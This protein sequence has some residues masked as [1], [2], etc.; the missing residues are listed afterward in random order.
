[1]DNQ[2][3]I[4]EKKKLKYVKI[5]DELHTMILNGVFP[6]GSQL[7][8]EPELSSQMKVS[9]MTLRKALALLQEDFLVQNIQGKGNFVRDFKD[10]NKNLTSESDK[11]PM[12]YASCM[13]PDSVELDVHLELPSD[14][15]KKNIQNDTAA[16]VV[17][18]RWFKRENE[19]IGYALTFIPIETISRYHVDL[20]NEQDVITFLENTLYDACAHRSSHYSVTTTGSFIT[21]RYSFPTST[22]MVLISETLYHEEETVLASS[23]FYLPSYHFSMEIN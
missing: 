18:D 16:V 19:L 8:S 6:A 7:P 21:K 15:I 9:R 22:P 20:S 5:Y 4:S 17:A 1:M 11:H 13:Q 3:K 14:F 12:N 10:F 2:K 23:K